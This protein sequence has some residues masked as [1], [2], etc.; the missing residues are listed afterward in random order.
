MNVSSPK[1]SEQTTYAHNCTEIRIV[2][3]QEGRNEK[4]NFLLSYLSYRGE[5]DLKYEV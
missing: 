1:Q 4:K 5:H 3:P 2:T